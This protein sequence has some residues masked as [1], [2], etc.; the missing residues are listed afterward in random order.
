MRASD[1]FE[2]LVVL[3][4]AEILRAR[5]MERMDEK[6][7]IVAFRS[8]R[9]A[10]TSWAVPAISY[11]LS[12]AAAVVALLFLAF[13]FF[14]FSVVGMASI[15]I[16]CM[17]WCKRSDRG[18]KGV[19]ITSKASINYLDKALHDDDQPEPRGFQ[20]FTE[21]CEP[22][23]TEGLSAVVAY[24]GRGGAIVVSRGNG[25][26]FAHGVRGRVTRKHGRRGA[27][28]SREDLDKACGAICKGGER[29]FVVLVV[30]A[31]VRGRCSEAI[32][33]QVSLEHLEGL[34][35]AVLL[36]FAD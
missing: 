16:D 3:T 23:R 36:K 11:L 2:R 33:R 5:K 32:H 9:T 18:G 10:S 15:W 4:S 26:P 21:A 20:E 6:A 7:S 22:R 13:F 17:P 19:W 14:V 34:R 29:R 25:A 1:E 31:P 28:T 8:A 30:V 27:H 24:R 12:E 35:Q